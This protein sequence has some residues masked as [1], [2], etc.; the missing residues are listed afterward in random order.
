M[1]L[2]GSIRLFGS[3]KTKKK[4]CRQDFLIVFSLTKS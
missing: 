1:H 2:N 3:D 4:G